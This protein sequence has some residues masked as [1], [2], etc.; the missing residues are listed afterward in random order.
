[1]CNTNNNNNNNSKKEKYCINF[2][3]PVDSQVKKGHAKLAGERA[4]IATILIRFPSDKILTG[5][6]S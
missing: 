6:R 2:V 3:V 4:V 5:V 1:M